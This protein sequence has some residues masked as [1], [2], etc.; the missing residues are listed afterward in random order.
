LKSDYKSAYDYFLKAYDL[1]EYGLRKYIELY[2]YLAYCCEELGF[3]IKSMSFLEEAKE[4]KSIEKKICDEIFI[5]SLLGMN[6]TSLNHTQKAKK[7]LDK[8][9]PIAL[10]NYEKDD[11]EYT[12]S[13]LGSVLCNY[14]CLYIKI[15]KYHIANEY[16]DKSLTYISEESPFHLE[17]SYQKARVAVATKNPIIGNKLISE[18]KELSKDNEIY[19]KMFEALDIMLNINDDLARKMEKEIIPYLMENNCFTP[20]Y[21][22]A[23]FIRDYHKEKHKPPTIRVGEISDIICTINDR[24][25][26]GGFI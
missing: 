13:L 20:A 2:R 10:M 6:Y 15:K 23:T 11:C 17:V 5:D 21:N 12:K 3:I 19:L 8:A 18:G 24:F 25:H 9:Y 16:I 7:Y 14:G 26:E 1:T 4:L 22:A